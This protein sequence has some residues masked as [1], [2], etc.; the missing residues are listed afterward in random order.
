MCFWVYEA[1]LI[2]VIEYWD[3]W[4]RVT[5]QNLL[6]VGAVCCI[7]NAG[8]IPPF[9]FSYSVPVAAGEPSF[10]VSQSTSATYTLLITGGT[11]QGFALFV[12]SVSGYPDTDLPSYYPDFSAEA[13][14]S[15][16]GCGFGSSAYNDQLQCEI[17]F[18]FGV[19]E[20]IAMSAT[21]TL[22]W[23]GPSEYIP[24]Y[25]PGT[26]E[27]SATAFGPEIFEPGVI[28]FTLDQSPEPGS[29]WLAGSVLAVSALFLRL[30]TRRG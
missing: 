19:A 24:D 28:S 3:A 29:F 10:R 23:G 14:V 25:T 12:D 2:G 30:R 1:R 26:I 18:T 13:F 22:A 5:V 15:V 17:P 20:Q 21:V 27:G 6:I 11:G 16:N 7:A 8:T 9:G 4:R